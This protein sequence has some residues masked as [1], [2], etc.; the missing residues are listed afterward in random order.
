MFKNKTE[1]E[2][3]MRP[4]DYNS[5]FL[6]ILERIHTRLKSLVTIELNSQKI[7]ETKKDYSSLGQ[8]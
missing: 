4:I 5:I 7:F 3:R 6:V 8:T 1:S 2:T